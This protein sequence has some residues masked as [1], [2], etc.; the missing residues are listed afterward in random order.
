MIRSREGKERG[1]VGE[2]EEKTA[3]RNAVKR[4][5]S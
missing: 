1:P 4:K 2:R 3:N 5:G